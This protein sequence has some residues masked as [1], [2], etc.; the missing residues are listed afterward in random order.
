M[1]GKVHKVSNTQP[2]RAHDEEELEDDKKVGRRIRC[3]DLKRKYL[4]AID[5]YQKRKTYLSGETNHACCLSPVVPEVGNLKNHFI[6]AEN[7]HQ[8]AHNHQ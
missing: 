4:N 3:G 1:F 2:E 7:L 6:F 5:I 8:H